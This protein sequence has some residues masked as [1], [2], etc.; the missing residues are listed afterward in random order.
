MDAQ[1][2]AALTCVKPPGRP[3]SISPGSISPAPERAV[4]PGGGRPHRGARAAVEEPL[5]GART[6]DYARATNAFACAAG[7]E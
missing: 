2:V 7:C 5:G 3:G 1:R 6:P 4:P